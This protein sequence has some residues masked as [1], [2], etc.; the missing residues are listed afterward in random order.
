MT[1]IFPLKLSFQY[2]FFLSLVNSFIAYLIWMILAKITPNNNGSQW[3]NILLS[4]IIV[5]VFTF[6]FVLL[7][8]KATEL[9]EKVLYT[10]TY[11][12]I[13]PALSFAI[14][15]LFTVMS[16]SSLQ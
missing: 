1:K 7:K 14:L 11:I 9:R 3:L 10:V 12:L 2:I 8:S 4:L 13:F 6:P 15:F 16:L 5:S